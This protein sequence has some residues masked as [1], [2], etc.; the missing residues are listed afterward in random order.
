MALKLK[1]ASLDLPRRCPATVTRPP[2]RQLVEVGIEAVSRILSDVCGAA[3]ADLAAAA[4]FLDAARDTYLTSLHPDPV[5]A[6]PAE[7]DLRMQQSLTQSD[8]RGGGVGPREEV[9]LQPFIPSSWNCSRAIIFCKED[10][11]MSR[12]DL[13]GDLL[14][15]RHPQFNPTRLLGGDD[16]GEVGRRASPSCSTTSQPSH[17]FDVSRNGAYSRRETL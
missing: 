11:H 4:A 9:L 2:S 7:I 12:L 13:L 10:P 8:A 3:A 6:N 17:R 14:R 16:R 5:K 15:S 1:A